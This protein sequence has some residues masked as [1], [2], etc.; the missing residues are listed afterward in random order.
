MP[1]SQPLH[2]AL[3]DLKNVVCDLTS[4][5]VQTYVGDLKVLIKDPKKPSDFEKLLK[6][7]TTSGSLKLALV[8]KLNFDGDGFVLVPESATPDYIQNA[9]NAALKAGNEVRQGL[10]SLFGDVIG[11]AV[12]K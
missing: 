7:G 3:E 9:H 1:N 5:E 8:T 10:L 4:I 6:A 2:K 11:L 12:S